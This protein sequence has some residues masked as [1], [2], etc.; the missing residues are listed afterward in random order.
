LFD[1]ASR[2]PS[3][4]ATVRHYIDVP[5]NNRALSLLNFDDVDRLAFYLKGKATATRC[6]VTNYDLEL[7][8]MFIDSVHN[9][10]TAVW[11]GTHSYDQ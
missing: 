5:K 2:S 6:N 10:L 1:G 8:S 7:V 9:D 4:L 11:F 3:H